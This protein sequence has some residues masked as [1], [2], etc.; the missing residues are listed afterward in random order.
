MEDPCADVAGK[1]TTFVCCSSFFEGSFAMANWDGAAK[2][3]D[4]SSREA[5]E[6]YARESLLATSANRN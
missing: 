3:S 6:E 5:E 1:G 2:D 4:C